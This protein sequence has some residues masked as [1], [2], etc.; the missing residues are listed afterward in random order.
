MT[1]HHPEDPLAGSRLLNREHIEHRAWEIARDEGRE[2]I[3]ENDRLRAEA[4][5]LPPGAP[6]PGIEL[7][8][9]A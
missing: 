2:V 5:L 6:V 4:E 7:Q 8:A 1:H 9:R 3:T